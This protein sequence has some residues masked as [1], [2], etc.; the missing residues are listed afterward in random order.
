MYDYN[1]TTT[2]IVK[3]ININCQEDGLMTPHTGAVQHGQRQSNYVQKNHRSLI[4]EENH[5]NSSK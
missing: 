2:I 1:Y 5:S 3:K 4:Q